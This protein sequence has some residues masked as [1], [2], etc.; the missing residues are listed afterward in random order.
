MLETCQSF[1]PWVFSASTSTG[2]AWPR[3]QVA[4][5]ATQSRYSSPVVE[6]RR[7]PRPRSNA[8][9]ARLYTP[10]MWCCEGLDDVAVLKTED[11]SD[12]E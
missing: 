6:N 11:D 12:E 10:M 1:S 7:A 3:P 9:G 5:P 2:W 4:M 8:S